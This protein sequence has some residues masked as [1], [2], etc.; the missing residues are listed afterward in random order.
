ME[1]RTSYLGAP[2]AGHDSVQPLHPLSILPGVVLFACGLR[3]DR[4]HLQNDGCPDVVF[5]E[6]GPR[7]PKKGPLCRRSVPPPA[8]QRPQARR[9]ILRRPLGWL[10]QTTPPSILA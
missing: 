1:A 6:S 8:P 3:G 2:R 10:L 4:R 7:I 9:E 5:A